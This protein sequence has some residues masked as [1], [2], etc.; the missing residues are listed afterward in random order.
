MLERD[1][2]QIK[3]QAR[4]VKGCCAVSRGDSHIGFLHHIKPGINERPN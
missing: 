2:C 3:D 1:N 4:Q